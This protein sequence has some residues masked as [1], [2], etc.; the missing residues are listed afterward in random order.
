MAT[1]VTYLLGAGASALALP[2]V[3]NWNNRIEEFLAFLKAII[4][5]Q[6]SQ[7]KHWDTL[8]GLSKVYKIYDEI[9]TTAKSHATIDTYARKLFLRKDYDKLWFLKSLLTAFFQYEQLDI[10]RKHKFKQSSL[11]SGK[12]IPRTKTLSLDTRYD[13]FFAALLN[14]DLQL[15]KNINIIT[16]NYDHQIE[17]AYTGFSEKNIANAQQKLAVYPDGD[18]IYNV[19]NKSWTNKLKDQYNIVKLNGSANT[20]S[21]LVPE[22][23]VDQFINVTDTVFEEEIFPEVYEALYHACRRIKEPKYESLQYH[24]NF[25]W[26]LQSNEMSKKGVELAKRIATDTDV[27]IVVGYS[28]PVFN[29]V[30]DKHIFGD[31]LFSKVY[32]QAISKDA[33]GIRERMEGLKISTQ[34]GFCI[35]EDLSQYYIPFEL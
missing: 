33:Q 30:I 11:I 18:A 31:K 26:E 28:F 4:T 27:L 20:L 19:N 3:A 17:L 15:P 13:T 7:G 6:S 14:E 21:H 35:Q 32:I 22:K 1:K 29:R 2:T 8:K 9:L 5:T 34:E 10:A 16:W 12:L 23:G 24:V 25:A